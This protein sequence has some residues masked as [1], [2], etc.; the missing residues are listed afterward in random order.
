MIRDIDNSKQPLLEHLVELRTRL[1]RSAFVIVIAF[2]PCFYYAQNIYNFLAKPLFDV[3][4]RKACGQTG[5]VEMLDSF[6]YNNFHFHILTPSKTP[7]KK[8]DCSHV[9]QQLKIIYTSPAEAFITYVKV[10]LFAS[11][12]I[13]LPF[14][15]WQIWGF[16]G[17]GLY[18]KEKL[19]VLPF[20]LTFPV[21][22]ILGAAVV[23][24]IFFPVALEFLLSFQQSPN[25]PGVVPIEAQFKISEYFSFL[26]KL[27][28]AFGLSFQLPLVV[29][30]LARMGLATSAGLREKRKYAIIGVFILAAVITP[31][32][33][34]S[35]C[36][37]AIPLLILYEVS[38]ICARFVEKSK[39]K[40]MAAEEAEYAAEDEP[41]S[42]DDDFD[43]TDFN[44]TR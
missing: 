39:A 20:M 31:P 13:S 2:I 14:L 18:R 8:P 16:I 9:Q 42:G 34:F 21:L 40:T 25:T 6:L 7:A 3:S 10:G 43:E 37:L 41:A 22:F 24:Y 32:D 5:D 28:F 44:Q 15:I 4:M 12:C 30:L 27:I 38:I 1:V 23:Y 26:L 29:T 33:P 17:P 11:L 19:V 35:Q 36:A